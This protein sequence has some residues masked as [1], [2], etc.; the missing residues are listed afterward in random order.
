[1]NTSGIKKRVDKLL[2]SYEDPIPPTDSIAF[3]YRFVIWPVITGD[4]SS[5]TERE[6]RYALD[7][8]PLMFEEGYSR[9]MIT[10]AQQIIRES[11][12]AK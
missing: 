7:L 4:V 5:L 6:K 10:K 1:M 9:D 2:G 8:D 3:Q 11:Q 12:K